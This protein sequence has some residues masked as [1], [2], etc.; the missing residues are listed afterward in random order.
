V[1]PIT[2]FLI[3]MVNVF[4]IITILLYFHVPQACLQPDLE[5]EA[6]GG[7]LLLLDQGVVALHKPL[8]L[9]KA[10]LCLN[11][12]RFQSWE[13]LA[14]AHLPASG[15]ESACIRSSVFGQQACER[16]RVKVWLRVQVSVPGSKA[17]Q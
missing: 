1:H 4:A 6:R 14:S 17:C 13:R 3:K 12:T 7:K 11:P 16:L 5:T 10:D 9:L 15:L 8:L 2:S